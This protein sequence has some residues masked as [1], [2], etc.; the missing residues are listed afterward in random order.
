MYFYCVSRVICLVHPHH[1]AA[2]L[3]S[4]VA[5]FSF[6]KKKGTNFYFLWQKKI[7]KKNETNVY[8]AIERKRLCIICVCPFSFLFFGVHCVC[9]RCKHK[10][11]ADC[12]SNI[13]RALC[14]RF[15][16]PAAALRY[17]CERSISFLLKTHTQK[18]RNL[19]L[20]RYKEKG[21]IRTSL[22]LRHKSFCINPTTTNKKNLKQIYKNLFPNL[23]THT[24]IYIY[25]YARNNI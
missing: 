7:N 14:A 25:K 5:Y 18:K 1:V 9:K 11:P 13:S 22:T 12:T 2:T 15:K 10:S 19:K 6:P 8:A 24:H 3:I 21:G 20:N 16:W 23:R 4:S 17:N